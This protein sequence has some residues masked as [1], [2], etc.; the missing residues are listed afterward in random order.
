[1]ISRLNPEFDDSTIVIIY[2]GECPFCSNY[3]R[4]LRLR[5][6]FRSVT[7]LDARENSREVDEARARGFD[8]NEGMV[9]RVSEQYYHGADAVHCLAMMSTDSGWFNQISSAVFRSRW[10]SRLLY[11]FLRAGRAFTLRL[12]G[13][14]MLAPLR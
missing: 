13:R 2:D 7:L 6:T 9:V 3:V 1:M 12:L 10:R 4:F 14:K 8:L 5:D 11:P